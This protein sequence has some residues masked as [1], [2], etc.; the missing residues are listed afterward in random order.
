MKNSFIKSYVGFT[1][2][3]IVIAIT[4]S[5]IV[6][7]GIFGFLMNLQ[8]DISQSKESTRIYTSLTDFIGTMNNFS[9]L[10]SSGTIIV[11]G[12]GIYNASLLMRPDKGA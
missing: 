10:Y 5:V 3:E 11:A 2:P 7:S 9:K 8:H 4:I 1:L 12:S 6:M